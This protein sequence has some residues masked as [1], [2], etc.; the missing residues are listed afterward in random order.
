[1]DCN[2]KK[3]DNIKW[4]FTHIECL[5]TGCQRSGFWRNLGWSAGKNTSLL[6]S[7]AKTKGGGQEMLDFG[8]VIGIRESRHPG[9]CK[10]VVRGVYIRYW[11]TTM[12]GSGKG[13]T[14]RRYDCWPQHGRGGGLP[15]DTWAQPASAWLISYQCFSSEESTPS[16]PTH[17]PKN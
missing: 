3:A 5:T 10:W 4:S 1:M 7:L 13:N 6:P 17:V 2:S 15:A 9:Q 14:G 16:F 12:C 11:Q 8:A